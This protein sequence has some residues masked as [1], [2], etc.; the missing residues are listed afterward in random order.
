MRVAEKLREA[1]ASMVT[2]WERERLTVT[3][4]L[5]AAPFRPGMGLEEC[6]RRADEALYQ[7]KSGGRNQVVLAGTQPQPVPA[8]PVVS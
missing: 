1:V 7:A 8:T 2:P 5:G 6:T 4:S 3:M